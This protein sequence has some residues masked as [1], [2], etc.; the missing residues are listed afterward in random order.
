MSIHTMKQCYVCK[1]SKTIEEFNTRK[2]RSG[3]V[4]LHSYC[5]PCQLA[6]HAQKKREKR[7]QLKEDFQ[8]TE[9]LSQQVEPVSDTIDEIIVE[10]TPMIETDTITADMEQAPT[11]EPETPIVVLP[12]VKTAK[13]KYYEKNKAKLLEKA[14]QYKKDNKEAIKKTKQAYFEKNQDKIR[15]QRRTYM[16]AYYAKNREHF[17]KYFKQ[18]RANNPEVKL[19]D[20]LSRRIVESVLKK[21]HTVDYLGTP[22]A[23]VKS[24]IESN[25]EADMSWKNYGSVWEI[26]HTVPISLFDLHD[27]DDTMV[28][29][30]WMNLFPM[31]GSKN[32]QKGKSI[33]IEAITKRKEL[34]HQFCTKNGKEEE[35]NSYIPS[36]NVCIDKITKK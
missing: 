7:K 24:W 18:Y 30:N 2:L 15:A 10:K 21:K 19:R 3:N 8:E 9:N 17:Q 6:Y 28:C 4:T 1:A 32:R 34:L 23:E 35:Y 20:A 12:K 29:F 16:K 27:D 25:F 36:Y 13:Q 11:I 33:L 22:I 31:Y 26:D 5:I 14:R